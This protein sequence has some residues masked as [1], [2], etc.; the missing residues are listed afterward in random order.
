MRGQWRVF[1]IFFTAWLFAACVNLSPALT[2]G[3]LA[4]EPSTPYWTTVPEQRRVARAPLG[5]RTTI[6]L[7][8]RKVVRGTFRGLETASVSEYAA[9]WSAWRVGA[10]ASYRLPAP[11]EVVHLRRGSVAVAGPFEGFEPI[12]VRLA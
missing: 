10:G 3:A 2:P 1:G 12:A 4:A 5:G 6:H 7:R 11:G 8:H 9:E